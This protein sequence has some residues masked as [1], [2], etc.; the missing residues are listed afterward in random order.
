MGHQSIKIQLQDRPE[1]RG[2]QLGRLLAQGEK[3]G[4]TVL[5]GPG[6]SVSVARGH[7]GLQRDTKGNK[8]E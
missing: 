4:C 7:Q 6:V 3:R 8:G 1:L 5:E 2:H